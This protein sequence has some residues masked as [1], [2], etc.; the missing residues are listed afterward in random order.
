MS[1]FH[2]VVWLDHSQAHVIHF[3][4]DSDQRQLVN[5]T[6]GAA[7][8]HHRTGAIGPG[9][10]LVDTPYFDA[11]ARALGDAQEILVAGPASAK[12]EFV[13][14]LERHDRA[15]RERIVAVEPLDHPTDNQ[16][17]AHARRYFE[18]TDRMRGV[19]TNMT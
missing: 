18:R 16:L 13:T 8:Q 2:A 7:H 14:H 15:L 5:S 12:N 9:R 17:L 19:P 11:I 1:L 3:N 10:A 4:R 6:L